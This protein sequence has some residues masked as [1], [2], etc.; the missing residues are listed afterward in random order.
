MKCELCQ[1]LYYNLYT[2]VQKLFDP[3]FDYCCC[4]LDWLYGDCHCCCFDY[5]D[6]N[7]C[8]CCTQ[9][10]DDYKNKEVFSYCYKYTGKLSWFFNFLSNEHQILIIV[11]SC[12]N[13]Y[14]QFI[15]I[16]LIKKINEE[17]INQPFDSSNSHFLTYFLTFILYLLL[18]HIFT[19]IIE[20]CC[21]ADEPVDEIKNK[22]L[23]VNIIVWTISSA[24]F[25]ISVIFLFSIV[26]SILYIFTEITFINDN[27]LLLIPIILNKFFYFTQSKFC[28]LFIGENK[29][30]EL[31]S[32]STTLSIYIL[33]WDVII[34][35]LLKLDIKIL[36]I[37]Q[38]IGSS[39]IILAIFISII[40]Y[41]FDL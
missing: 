23:G 39:L 40:L 11:V 26:F 2:C 16:G 7:C 13:F 37:I 10:D 18:S 8:N 33:F 12:I 17:I 4:C 3:L 32:N 19:I 20:K 9:F 38:F 30:F 29:T 31:L 27:N 41:C 25:I 36:Y 34:A 1:R 5:I 22:V 15:T 6:C 28:L 35:L 24:L 21:M 14:L